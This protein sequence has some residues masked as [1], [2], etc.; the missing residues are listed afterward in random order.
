MTAEF[1]WHVNCD[2]LFVAK[3]FHASGTVRSA[4]DIAAINLRMATLQLSGM[5]VPPRVR[6]V[7]AL[8]RRLYV[9]MITDP[10]VTV[11][12]RQAGQKMDSAVTGTRQTQSPRA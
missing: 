8:R 5:R 12:I 6:K 7:P 1:L 4:V 9:T 11:I 2:K 10:P 3:K